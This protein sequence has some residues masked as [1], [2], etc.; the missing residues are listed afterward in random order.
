[1]RRQL[2]NGLT[3]QDIEDGAAWRLEYG[4]RARSSIIAHV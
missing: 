1:V 4:Q 2:S 3:A